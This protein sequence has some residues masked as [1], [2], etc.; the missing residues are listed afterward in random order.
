LDLFPVIS[1]TFIKLYNFAY[2]FLDSTCSNV[3]NKN[4]CIIEEWSRNGIAMNSE[5]G[6]KFLRF[7]KE[8]SNLKL[9]LFKKSL[10]STIRTNFILF[11]SKQ[12]K[13]SPIFASL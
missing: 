13:I 7:L 12:E 9:S 8:I 6:S 4:G 3:V 1:E 11:L 5:N 2:A 10:V